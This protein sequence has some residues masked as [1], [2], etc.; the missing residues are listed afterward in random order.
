[1]SE[2][3]D[4]K[5]YR[6]PG[7]EDQDG[8]LGCRG[9]SSCGSMPRGASGCGSMAQLHRMGG[10]SQGG[11]DLGLAS[12]GSDSSGCLPPA[13]PH[14]H[15]SRSLPEE[16]VEMK[17]SG[18]SGSGTE[19]HGNESHGNQSRGNQSRGNQSH[20]NESTGSSNGNSKDSALLESSGSNKRSVVTVGGT[21]PA[22]THT[23]QLSLFCV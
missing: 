21:V 3:S 5:L 11:A 23:I 4:S 9:V 22:N 20:G 10:Y 8:A 17:S 15:R 12:E 6:F 18:S 7:L 19:S 14:G 1:M 16:D 2:D 13:S